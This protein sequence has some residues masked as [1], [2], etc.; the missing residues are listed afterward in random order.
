MSGQMVLLAMLSVAAVV[1]MAV[2][3]V[4]IW[5][6]QKTVE[7]LSVQ[8]DRTLDQIQK[9]AEDIRGTNGE[10]RR[11]MA[12]L[13]KSAANVEHVT[14][15]V[16]GFRKTLDAASSVLQFAVVPVLGSVAGGLAGVK[17]AASH[18]AN[19]FRRKEGHHGE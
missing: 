8:V 18:M 12:H 10:V 1:L 17:A 15:G 14:E 13:E 9:L 11:F 6:V 7:R 5:R 19:R 16:R 4:T 3:A 2:V